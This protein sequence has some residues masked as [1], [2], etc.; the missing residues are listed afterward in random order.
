MKATT[1]TSSRPAATASTSR[2]AVTNHTEATL[3]AAESAA[4]RIECKKKKHANKAQKMWYVYF[5]PVISVVI[6]FMCGRRTMLVRQWCKLHGCSNEALKNYDRWV[7]TTTD[8]K[9]SIH[10]FLAPFGVP[11]SRVRLPPVVLR[12]YPVAMMLGPVCAWYIRLCP[13]G[14][15]YPVF[16]DCSGRHPPHLAN[17]RDDQERQTDHHSEDRHALSPDGSA[18]A[19]SVVGAR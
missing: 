6:V 11:M 4:K 7:R 19:R 13:C 1:S 14:R 15:L 16:P 10:L 2:R 5:R 3:A 12:L 17:A 18:L 8:A 9:R